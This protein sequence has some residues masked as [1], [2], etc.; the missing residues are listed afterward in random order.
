M[1]ATTSAAAT[2][3]DL[4]G[5]GVPRCRQWRAGTQGRALDVAQVGPRLGV[6]QAGQVHARLGEEGRRPADALRPEHRAARLGLDRRDHG[7]A[8]HGLDRWHD[9]A[10][11][12][13][14][15]TDR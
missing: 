5:L 13:P 9:A 6:G 12:A 4:G 7:P 3:R 14:T 11:A 15:S 10:V 1:R 8:W 2:A